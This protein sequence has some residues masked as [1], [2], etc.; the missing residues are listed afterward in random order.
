M[1]NFKFGIIGA[2][3]IARKFVGAVKM[4]DGAEVAAVASNTK[5]KAKAFAEELNIP[6]YYEGYEEMVARPDIDA[7][8]IATTHNFHYQN[9][10][11]ALS[12]GKHVICEKCFMTNADEAKEIFALAKEKN[13]FCMEAMWSRFLPAINK[14]KE[15]ISEG[16]L[17]EIDLA[18]FVIGFKSTEDSENRIRNPKLGGGAM[19]D[20]GVY[21]IEIMTYLID[22]RLTGVK[23]VVTK[24]KEGVDKV[25]CILLQF[26]NCVANLQ[27]IITSNVPNSLDIYG[28]KG[29]I[30]IEN[31]HYSDKCVFFDSEGNSEEF[32]APLENGFEFQIEEL[33]SC[34]RKGKLESDVIPHKDTIL[35]AEI[36]DKCLNGEV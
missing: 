26:E 27:A 29:R 9:A 6:D 33:I 1:E 13:L 16:R 32:S 31:P 10:K 11:L 22:E 18:S 24:T 4:V 30:H 34:V 7:V 17:G 36:F 14:A 23:S 15:W 25:D 5:G 19:F 2:G 28:T 12:N 8:Y 35:C 20:I 21:A 3:N